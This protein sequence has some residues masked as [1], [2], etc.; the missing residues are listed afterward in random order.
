MAVATSASAMDVITWG[1]P[2][3]WAVPAWPS[4]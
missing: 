2:A 3:D 4:P 1:L